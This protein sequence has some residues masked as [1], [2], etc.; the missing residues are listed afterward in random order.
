VAFRS[1][2]LT[3]N[4]IPPGEIAGLTWFGGSLAVI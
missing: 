4:R 3:D 2:S 1:S